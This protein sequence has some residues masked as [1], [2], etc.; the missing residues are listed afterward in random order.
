MRFQ[1]LLATCVLFAGNHALAQTTMPGEAKPRFHDKG[2]YVIDTQ[3]GLWWQKDGEQSGKRN[4]A[5]AAEYAAG[6]KLG[7][8]RGWRVPTANELAAIFPADQAPFTNSAYNKDACCAGPNEFRSYWTCELDP[9]LDDYAYVYHWYAKGGANNCFASKNFVYVRCV[10]DP[11][12][13]APAGAIAS[14]PDEKPLTEADHK[15]VQD[16]IKQLGDDRFDRRE[17][18]LI[19]LKAF[20]RKALPLL[21]AA[22]DKTEDA[23]VRF[24]LKKLIDEAAP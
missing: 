15:Q 3:T 22:L 4:F 14:P 23:E 9:R 6:L 20:G 2:E 17:A 21:S 16:W 12:G 5:D 1:A 7:G 8:R 19:G 13:V 24:R 11:K 10:L 18:A